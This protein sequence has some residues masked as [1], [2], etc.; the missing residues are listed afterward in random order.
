MSVSYEDAISTLESMFPKW[1]KGTLGKSLQIFV[2]REFSLMSL[3]FMGRKAIIHSHSRLLFENIQKYYCS[4]IIIMWRELLM[5]SSLW[6]KIPVL[7]KLEGNQNNLMSETLYSYC[8]D[9]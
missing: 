9:I 4:K 7:A 3:Q 1:D 2:E 6:K 5:Q 8:H